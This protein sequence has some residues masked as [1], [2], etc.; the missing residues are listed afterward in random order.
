MVCTPKMPR[1]DACPVSELCA[2]FQQGKQDRIPG[3]KAKPS[4]EAVREAAVVIWNR[5]KVFV[6]R[7]SA[8]ERWAGLWDFVRFPLVARRGPSLHRE[9]NEKVHEQT[10]LAIGEVQKIAT[11]KHGVTR[12]RITL[13]CYRAVY[14]KSQV[15]LPAD[16][17]RWI[18]P[19]ELELLP[20]SVTGR[21]LSRLI[22]PE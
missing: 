8:G 2:A 14:A 5:G 6:R 19:E 12:F 10:G 1:C 15:R 20:L 22:E 13:D 21:K 18:A 4:I 9:M 16:E 7:R 11:L 3:A 17:W